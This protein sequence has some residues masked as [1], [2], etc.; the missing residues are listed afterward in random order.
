MAHQEFGF[1]VLERV[2]ADLEPHGVVEQFPKMEGR[3]MVMVMAPK[4]KVIPT[5]AKKPAAA[6]APK[7]AA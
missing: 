2:K 7:Q 4:K 1:R 3:Q 6:G 5:K